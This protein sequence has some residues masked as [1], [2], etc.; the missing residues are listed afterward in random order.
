MVLVYWYERR[1]WITRVYN[2]DTAEAYLWG[3]PEGSECLWLVP[4]TE[5]EDGSW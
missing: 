4:G 1:H 3:L 2:G 5:E